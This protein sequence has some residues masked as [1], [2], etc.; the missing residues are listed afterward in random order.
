MDS[1]G[2]SMERFAPRGRFL[3][4]SR[5]DGSTGRLRSTPVG[6]GVKSISRIAALQYKLADTGPVFFRQGTGGRVKPGKL[7]LR[8]VEVD[9]TIFILLG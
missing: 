7:E 6:G 4:C 8:D 5:T 1:L 9:C 2:L 3:W